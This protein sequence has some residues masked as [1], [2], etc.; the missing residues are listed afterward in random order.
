MGL[1]AVIGTG[2]RLLVYQPSSCRQLVQ[3]KVFWCTKGWRDCFGTR[4]CIVVCRYG[5]DN[6]TGQTCDI[7][8][9]V[10]RNGNPPEKLCNLTQF[11]R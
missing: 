8:Q 10:H 5:R 6:T 11:V 7:K 2:E 4:E 9:F 3:E 1:G